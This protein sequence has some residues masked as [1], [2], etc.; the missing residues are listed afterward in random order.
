MRSR[1]IPTTV[2]D[3]LRP[4]ADQGSRI[5]ERREYPGSNLPGDEFG[6]ECPIR[7]RCSIFSDATEKEELKERIKCVSKQ[8]ESLRAYLIP[9]T[10]ANYQQG[11]VMKWGEFALV[12][13]GISEELTM[14]AFRE[15]RSKAEN[16]MN[17]LATLLICSARKWDF[18]AIF[19]DLSKQGRHNRQHIRDAWTFARKIMEPIRRLCKVAIIHGNSCVSEMVESDEKLHLALY[20]DSFKLSA[21]LLRFAAFGQVVCDSSIRDALGK[22]DAGDTPLELFEA[23]P[24][25]RKITIHYALCSLVK[26]ESSPTTVT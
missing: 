4:A 11:D 1:D 20:S 24:L 14:E 15:F 7:G 22:K 26:D 2:R 16:S 5:L 17:M 9:R 19:T 10:A 18:F 6:R 8:A 23:G 21:P 12:E 25:E 13:V 3:W